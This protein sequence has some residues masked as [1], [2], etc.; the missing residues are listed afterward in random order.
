MNLAAKNL[1]ERVESGH[2]DQ[3]EAESCQN[4]TSSELLLVG[5]H[6]NVAHNLTIRRHQ[7]TAIS[8]QAEG[9]E[10]RALI[11]LKFPPDRSRFFI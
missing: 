2:F 3:G 6:Q 9:G 10:T 11:L 8:L 7:I 4:K 1:D 5:Q